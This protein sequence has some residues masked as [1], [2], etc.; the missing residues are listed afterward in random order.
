VELS[1]SPP[2]PLSGSPSIESRP[3]A[4]PVWTSMRCA[5]AGDRRSSA[6]MSEGREQHVREQLRIVSCVECGSWSDA[7]WRGWRAYRVDDP[8]LD[9]PPA[10]GLYCPACAEAEFG[11]DV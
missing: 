6:R 3:R 1:R 8:E 5:G 4:D 11:P 10:L 9:E 7:D 2:P